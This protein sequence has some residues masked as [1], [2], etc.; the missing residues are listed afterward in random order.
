MGSLNCVDNADSVLKR[1]SQLRRFCRIPIRIPVTE[2]LTEAI[3]RTT[4]SA[5]NTDCNNSFSFPMHA[6]GASISPNTAQVPLSHPS[7]VQTLNDSHN[8]SIQAPSASSCR[9]IK[10]AESHHHKKTSAPASTPIQCSMT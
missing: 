2:A 10:L 7:S 9:A 1:I 3:D 5:S 4:T 8:L 6:L